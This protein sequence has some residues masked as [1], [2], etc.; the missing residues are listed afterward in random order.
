MRVAVYLPLLLTLFATPGARLLAARCEPRL[1]TWL[2]T[3]SSLVLAAA[4]ALSLGLLTLTG[5]LRVPELAELGQWS[6]RLAARRDPVELSVAAAAGL[7]LALAT[8]AAVRV[9]AN[10]CRTLAR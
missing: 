8:V 1:A 9:F 2:L 4:G 5:L 3:L 6:L 10:R 7:L